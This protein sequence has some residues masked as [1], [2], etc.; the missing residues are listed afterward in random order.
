MITVFHAC[1]YFEVI[2]VFSYFSLKALFFYI[3]L[4]YYMLLFNVTYIW[5]YM[6]IEKNYIEL[7]LTLNSHVNSKFVDSFVFQ[8][9]LRIKKFMFYFL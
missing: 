4:C 1:A 5:W 8:Y 3:F 9:C 2:K 7:E 6:E